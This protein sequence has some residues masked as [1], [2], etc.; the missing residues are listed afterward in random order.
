MLQRIAQHYVGIKSPNS[1]K[2]IILAE[3]QYRQHKICFDVLYYATY[4]DY[5]AIKEEIGTKEGEYIRKYKPLL[6][7]QIPKSDDWHK[8]DVRHISIKDTLNIL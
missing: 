1:P 7:A 8:F 5:F 4:H 2:Y 6:N 3:A